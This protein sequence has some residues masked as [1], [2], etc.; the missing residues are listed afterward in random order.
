MSDWTTLSEWARIYEWVNE[1]MV[2]NEIGWECGSL[3]KIEM[4][5]WSDG[6]NERWV[7][8]TV[9]EKNHEWVNDETCEWMGKL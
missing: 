6:V 7:E 1:N 3:D 2:L 4:G 9:V 8:S 5:E